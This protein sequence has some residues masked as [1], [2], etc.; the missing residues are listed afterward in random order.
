MA[1]LFSYRVLIPAKDAATV[2][3]LDTGDPWMV[4]RPYRK[5]RVI[6]MAGPLDAEGGTL[7]VNP[8]FVPLMHEL[9]F[10]LAD[11]AS[12]SKP[13]KP[14]D[15][16]RVDLAE[17]PAEQF[18]HATVTL[19]D[20]GTAKAPIVRSGGKARVQFDATDEPGTYQITLP[21]PTEGPAYYS[22]AG[23]AREADAEPLAASE[24][25][26]LAEGWPMTFEA[27]PDQLAGR[28][29]ASG[30][31]GPRPLWRGFV[32]LALGGLC[33]EVWMTRK[34]VKS[35]GIAAVGEDGA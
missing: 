2:A 7:P 18:Q 8:D 22:V 35:R 33:L 26:K 34:L 16:I 24:S 32:L 13:L 6:V 5:G 21:P 30:S 29:L 10:R 20:G 4:E 14:G 31:S 27:A 3:R 1:S 19:P 28:L 11:P 25:A 9:V 17:I 23:D 12:D 15:S